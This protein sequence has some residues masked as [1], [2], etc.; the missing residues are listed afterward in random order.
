[1]SQLFHSRGV[2]FAIPLFFF[3]AAH[4]Q[5][6]TCYTPFEYTP[7]QQIEYF[8][9]VPAIKNIKCV[10]H[11]HYDTLNWATDIQNDVILEAID[12]LNE[13]FLWYDFTFELVKIHH[14][15]LWNHVVGQS[16]LD[17]TFCFPHDYNIMWNYAHDVVY[18]RDEFMNI[19]IV[20]DMCGGILGFAY[21]SGYFPGDYNYADGVW[22][23]YDVFGLDTPFSQPDR[24]Q[25]KTLVHE[26]GH[27][28]G[29]LHVFQGV[30]NCG[31]DADDDCS[32][33]HDKICDTP[34]TKVN[35]DCGNPTCPPA[36]NPTRPWAD[37]VHNNHM[38]YYIDSCRTAFTAGQMEF[39]HNHMS[40]ERASIIM[41]PAY[42]KWADANNDYISGTL[43]LLAILENYGEY[44]S[45]VA[46][47][48]Y[49]GDGYTGTEDLLLLLNYYG[50]QWGFEFTPFFS[51][52]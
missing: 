9:E 26:V 12:D 11:V 46:E 4:A 24:N 30:D 13:E 20:P 28:F 16:F 1:M 5:D 37:Y 50:T 35:W 41:P 43:D 2:A 36:W 22:V 38:D 31:E 14:W 21:R 18:E 7:P 51:F 34:P 44:T 42:V 48:D 39:M 33:I 32:A 40:S 47:G 45:G 52:D 15:N 10:V 27:Y 49:T 29:L 25:N 23:Q 17:G 19:H 8:D 3:L 6:T